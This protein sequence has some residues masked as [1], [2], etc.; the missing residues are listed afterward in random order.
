MNI[1]RVRRFIKGR[2][3]T[4]LW[5][6]KGIKIADRVSVLGVSPHIAGKGAIELGSLVSFRGFGSRSWFH[7]LGNARL[8]IGS[9]SFINSGVMIDVS[10]A[11]SIG[12]NCLVG[13]CVVIQ[14]S[15]YHE[16]DEGAGVK[17]KAVVIGDNVWI[18]RNSIILPGVEIGD[19]SVIGAGSVVTKSVPPHSLVAG[20]PARIIRE[21]AASP[22][23]VR[24]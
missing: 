23:Y 4:F 12:K 10:T 9:R 24:F 22:G 11:V 20:N 18:G 5:R 17:T 14:D 3:F 19:H 7:V 13:D 21:I 2:I 1:Y 15:N 6:T 16:I 8:S